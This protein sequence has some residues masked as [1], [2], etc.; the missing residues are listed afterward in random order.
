MSGTSTGT[1]RDMA[2]PGRMAAGG[3]QAG[4]HPPLRG[5][6]VPLVPLAALG[7]SG[8]VPAIVYL[9]QQYRF[10]GVG[11]HVTKTGRVVSTMVWE[12]DCAT[13]GHA[14]RL[15]TAGKFGPSRR[16]QSCKAPG[17]RVK[18]A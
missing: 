18:R 12:T 9:G 16:C 3:T 10:E 7:A 13:C 2:G 5:G 17:V 4:R 11:E 6:D 14:F 15:F 1:C 8:H